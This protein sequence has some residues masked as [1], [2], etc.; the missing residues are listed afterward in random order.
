MIYLWFLTYFLSLWCTTLY[1]LQT[2][3]HQIIFIEFIQ[4]IKCNGPHFHYPLPIGTSSTVI[5][6]VA[7]L[8]VPTALIHPY[9]HFLNHLHLWKLCKLL[10][11]MIIHIHGFLLY[12][13]HL[14]GLSLKSP[15]ALEIITNPTP[16]PQL[17]PS[18][19]NLLLCW[20]TI[21]II[22]HCPHGPRF[23]LYP[24]HLNSLS[25]KSSKALKAITAPTASCCSQI[26]SCFWSPLDL[27]NIWLIHAGSISSVPYLLNRRDFSACFLQVLT[28]AVP[29]NSWTTVIAGRYN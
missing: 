25:L 23:L 10:L 6:S 18:R 13:L 26:S 9:S 20:L 17:L 29:T 5:G 1:A 24:L 27:I 12:P 22:I 4:Q 11:E 7:F 8:P 16:P 15:K 21:S 14:K 2:L 28:L 19:V 3:N